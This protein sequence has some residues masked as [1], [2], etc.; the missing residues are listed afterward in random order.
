MN[1]WAYPQSTQAQ[2]TE[3]DV[4]T[5]SPAKEGG[6]S[7]HHKLSASTSQGLSWQAAPTPF[8]IALANQKGGVA[9]TTSVV[10]LAGALGQN[11]QD[12]LAIDLDA[13]A[14]LTLALGKDPSRVRRA[15][16]EVLFNS[17]SLISISQETPVPGLDLAPADASMEL[18][19]RFLPVRKNYETILRSAIQEISTIHHVYDYIFLDC[20]PSIGAVTLNAMNAAD[21]LII[22]TQPEYFSAHALLSMMTTIQEI[23][24]GDN[25][26]LVY[27]ILITMFDQRNRIHRDV[28][29]QIR[30]T[31]QGGVFTTT[32]GIDTKIKE[33]ALEGRP[34]THFKNNSRGSLQYQAL[35]QELIAYVQSKSA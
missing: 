20:P 33:S 17:G 16:S 32:I 27:R 8:V 1:N 22:P 6:F 28:E 35:A 2:K 4:H 10:S 15:I 12:I 13:Q 31:F 26:N 5:T 30:E 24:K 19:E 34:I 11:E 9:K 25:P 21:L 23:R 3:A 14:N 7:H 29:Q 18:A